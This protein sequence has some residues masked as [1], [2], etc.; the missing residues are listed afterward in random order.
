MNSGDEEPDLLPLRHRA[1]RLGQR[2]LADRDD[3][4]RVLGQ[5]DERVRRHQTELRV[6][7]PQ[8]RLGRHAATR[9]EV[10]DRLDH[11]AELLVL[12]RPLEPSLEIEPGVERRAHVVVEHLDPRLAALLRLVHRGIGVVQQ[13][14][15]SAPRA[16]HRDPEAR[17]QPA[18]VAVELQR[19][20]DR[21][22]EATGQLARLGLGVHRVEPGAQHRELVA[23]EASD[24]V[25]R[26]HRLLEAVRDL[27]EQ[28]VAGVVAESVVDVLEPVDVQE[29]DGDAGAVTFGPA[30]VRCRGSRRTAPGWEA[31]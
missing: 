20:L 17:R 26:S 15:R 5:T 14:L 4:P 24:D 18:V 27:S 12:D 25:T 16:R 21:L 6:L 10:D 9:G 28:L 1:A 13:A 11:Q 3:Q 8:E 19:A 23:A 22:Q 2:P 7:P 30:R 29:Q 31:R